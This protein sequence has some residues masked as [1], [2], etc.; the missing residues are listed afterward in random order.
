MQDNRYSGRNRR[1]H[2]RIRYPLTG[3][4]RLTISDKEYEVIDLSESG[5]KFLCREVDE[6]TA[7]AAVRV[8][9]TF[10][11]G[12]SLHVKGKI[13]RTA[14]KVSVI[15]FSEDIPFGRILKEQ[16]Y[17]KVHYPEYR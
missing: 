1:E 12:E 9:I 10:N 8:T 14:E 16:R 4:P 5:L 7:G 17:L 13:L 11:D 15:S 2:Y 3:R 6:F